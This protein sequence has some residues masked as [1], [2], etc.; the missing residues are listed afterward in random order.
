MPA[1]WERRVAED[2]ISTGFPLRCKREKRMPPGSAN[3]EGSFPLSS[4]CIP[5][6]LRRSAGSQDW[7]PTVHG[8]VCARI[9]AV[10][11]YPASGKALAM[12][13]LVGCGVPIVAFLAYVFLTEKPYRAQLYESFLG[14]LPALPELTGAPWHGEGG[15]SCLIREDRALSFQ[16]S[17]H[18]TWNS[19]LLQ[20]ANFND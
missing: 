15:M 8:A 16:P 9:D 7:R 14:F 10:A 4:G 17:A 18:S 12:D 13:V 6:I 2:F 11:G 20:L 1:G 3:H 19:Q 5:W